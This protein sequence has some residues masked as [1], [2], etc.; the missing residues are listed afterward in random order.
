MLVSS[1]RGIN[2]PNPNRSDTA[3]VPRDIGALV[4]AVEAD[5]IYGQGTLAARPN[6]TAGTPGIVG[7]IYAATDQ[8]PH[9][10]YWDYGTGWDAL[11]T[12][13]AGSV[14]TTQL[15]DDS[16]TGGALGAGVKIKQAT[17]VG[18]NLVNDTITATQIAAQGVGVAE[19]T[20]TIKPS[21][22]ASGATEALR[23]LG[24]AAGTAAAGTHASQHS[25]TGADPLVI[26]TF[27][28]SGTLAS[29]PSTSLVA[30]MLYT[31][32]D[33]EGGQEY[34]YNGTS[35]VPTGRSVL[36]T[37]HAVRAKQATP[38]AITQG[39]TTV[40]TL[41]GEDFDTDTLHDLVTNNSRVT[42]PSALAGIWI[43]AGEVTYPNPSENGGWYAQIRKN[44]TTY[45][46]AAGNTQSTTTDSN[47]IHAGVS[48]IDVA[49]ASDYYELL[50]FQTH[51]PGGGSATLVSASLSATLI[52]A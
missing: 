35:W 42:I 33:T 26:S 52:S 27:V 39:T 1:R 13:A 11:G 45:L 32:T 48:I 40:V 50:T 7:R 46:A 9:A 29:R 28:G 16:I 41:D 44:G 12:L 51:S 37:R 8:T 3:D 31:A 19:L 5:V 43:I 21:A 25:R 10:F 30:G 24:T 36:G 6:S 18:G 47:R 17:I 15:A 4:T 20:D 34:Q 23:A 38:Q 49:A 14:G 22:G 2:Y